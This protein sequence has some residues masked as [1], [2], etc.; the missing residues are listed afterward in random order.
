M[1]RLRRM[2]PLR[3]DDRMTSVM[4]RSAVIERSEVISSYLE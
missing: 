3:I 4:A 2:T 1:T